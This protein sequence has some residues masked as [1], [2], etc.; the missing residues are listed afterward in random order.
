M[1][2]YSSNNSRW[3]RL[4]SLFVTLMALITINGRARAESVESVVNPKRANNTWVS[5]MASVLDSSTEQ[6]LNT[7]LNNLK[8]D[9]GAEMA[10]VTIRR[11]DGATPKQFAT[12]LFNR[13]G[14]G[15]KSSDNGVLM[16]LVLDARR[17][18]V[19]TGNGMSSILPAGEVQDVLQQHVIPRFKQ[20]DYPG[21]VVAGSADA[22][23]ENQGRRYRCHARK[24]CDSGF[25]PN[26]Y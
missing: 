7:L 18:E 8:R 9:T 1:N 2:R 15:Q 25:G 10:V 16:L 5:D 19:E 11:T 4:V 17:I 23:A 22:G 3:L 20:N 14:I 13:W 12:R 24:I 6:R 21:G 26:F